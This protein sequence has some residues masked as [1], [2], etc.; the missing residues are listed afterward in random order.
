MIIDKTKGDVCIIGAG[1]VGCCAAALGLNRLG[2]S[3]DLVDK[4][5]KTLFGKNDSR[6]IVLSH[7]SKK[8]LQLPRVMAAY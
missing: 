5:P 6:A 7:T 8:L 3:I 1:F 4:R 2:F